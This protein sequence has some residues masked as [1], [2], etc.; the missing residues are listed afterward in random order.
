M[1]NNDIQSFNLYLSS[2]DINAYSSKNTPC[3][4]RTPLPTSLFL[5][6][7]H[8]WRVAL[9]HISVSNE[10]ENSSDFI[11]VNTSLIQPEFNQEKCIAVLT[12][13]TSQYSETF[14]HSEPTKREYYN[15]ATTHISTIE[16]SLTDAKGN[17]LEV[18][19]SQPTLII[20]HFQRMKEKEFIVRFD[21]YDDKKGT[22]SNFN[23]AIPPSL[24]AN[25]YQ[26]WKVSLNSIIH[27]GDFAQLPPVEG[28]KFP[29]YAK[30]LYKRAG[31]DDSMALEGD[32]Y[33]DTQTFIGS[34]KVRNNVNLFNI[35]K[36]S[37][38]GMNYL[39]ADRNDKPTP[40][41][42]FIRY[43]NSKIRFEVRTPC[44]VRFPY[45]WA[46][47]MGST[48]IPDKNGYVSYELEPNNI[49]EFEK[50]ADY[51]AW[52]PQYM[53]LYTNF[54]DYS[55]FGSQFVPIL[56]AIPLTNKSTTRGKYY[57]YEPKMDEYHNVTFSQI[58]DVNFKLCSINGRLIDFSY[59]DAR[60]I[61]TLKFKP[62]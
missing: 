20:L 53:L 27:T 33:R 13:N 50:A 10:I 49:F 28:D 8:N 9:S 56:R 58:Q 29:I 26:K 3:D 54:I 1:I 48:K 31:L 62:I 18:Q 35:V 23:G 60:I 6:K 34:G 43:Y 17:K 32:E 39:V 51:K 16:I 57:F 42:S 61:L 38:E 11:K 52:I 19:F 59:R 47:L 55:P 25:P 36:K 24:G 41:F 4:F 22:A 15:I 37:L 40:L 7:E 12:K 45:G 30:Y 21:S 44:T 5:P 14:K 46:V 2:G